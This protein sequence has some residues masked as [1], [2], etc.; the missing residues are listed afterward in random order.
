ML[1]NRSIRRLGTLETHKLRADLEHL[2]TTGLAG[3]LLLNRHVLVLTTININMDMI[4]DFLLVARWL[5]GWT[6]LQVFGIR[7]L[8]SQ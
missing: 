3:T 5:L 7:V 2:A 1:H 6:I 8:D 4:D